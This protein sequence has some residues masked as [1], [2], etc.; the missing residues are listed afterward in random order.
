MQTTFWPKPDCWVLCTIMR[1]QMGVSTSTGSSSRK[2]QQQQT[3][4]R[5]QLDRREGQRPLR[6]G[7]QLLGSSCG[8]RLRRWG[9]T[10]SGQMNLRRPILVTI[11]LAMCPEPVTNLPV[12]GGAKTAGGGL[13]AERLLLSALG[14]C[15]AVPCWC[16][17]RMLFVTNSTHL[18]RGGAA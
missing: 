5:Q 3:R 4:H 6:P 1:Q 16:E 14:W 9:Y 15:R 17:V 12:L 10:M 8:C 13:A 2:R 11:S 7:G 18:C